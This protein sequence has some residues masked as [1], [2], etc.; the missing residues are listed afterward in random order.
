MKLINISIMALGAAGSLGQVAPPIS[1]TPTTIATLAASQPSSSV[2]KASPSPRITS[3]KLADQTATIT[4]TTSASTSALPAP[5]NIANVN[6]INDPAV[7]E[8]DGPRRAIIAGVSMFLGYLLICGIAAL[9]VKAERLR[10]ERAFAELDP[11]SSGLG[12]FIADSRDKRDTKHRV[13]EWAV[14][15][16]L[17]AVPFLGWFVLYRYMRTSREMREEIEERLRRRASL[18]WSGGSSM[19]DS[20]SP[21]RYSY[22]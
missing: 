15:A 17:A 10:I 13:A 4:Y 12:T 20:G 11:L 7:G 1:A 14:L 5:S 3:P 19:T 6:T 9:L 21:Y 8:H 18:G 22:F 2:L 16:L